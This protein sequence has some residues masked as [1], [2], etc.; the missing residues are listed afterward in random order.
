MKG[1]DSSVLLRYILEDDPIW[2]K[3]ATR[4]ID[5][6]CT[7][8]DPAY[9]NLVVLAEVV[10]SLRRQ[11]NYGK[12]VVVTVVR[13]M[14]ESQ[15]V[16]LEKADIVADALQIFEEGNAGFADCLISSLNKHVNA[17]PTF[18]FDKDAVRA[19]VFAHIKR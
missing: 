15:S 3:A 4:F 13:N 6:E 9:V 18:S 5:E 14:L 2:S 17:E 19:G 8:S 1:I 12:E 10:W 16:V 11:K 7:A